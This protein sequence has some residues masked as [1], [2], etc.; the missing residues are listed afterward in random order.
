MIQ[1]IDDVI[2]PIIYRELKDFGMVKTDFN[3]SKQK[4]IIFPNLALGLF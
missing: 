2:F 1:N 4:Y 3:L